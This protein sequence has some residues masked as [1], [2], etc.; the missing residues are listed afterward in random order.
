MNS[1]KYFTLSKK[2]TMSYK[3]LIQ[4]IKY[5]VKLKYKVRSYMEQ[6]FLL[7]LHQK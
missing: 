5:S 7:I 2:K 6:S 1:L 3:V 4:I